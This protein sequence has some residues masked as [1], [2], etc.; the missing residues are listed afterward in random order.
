VNIGTNVATVLDIRARQ[1]GRLKAIRQSADP[2][3]NLRTLYNQSR[4]SNIHEDSD[5]FDDSEDDSLES[6][7]FEDGF[8]DDD[9]ADFE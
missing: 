7:G 2:Y 5:P 4:E 3:V 9:F 1:D 8:S 6:D